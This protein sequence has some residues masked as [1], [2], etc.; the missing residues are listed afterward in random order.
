MLCVCVC[1]G[2]G[3]ET[4]I[5]ITDNSERMRGVGFLLMLSSLARPSRIGAFCSRNIPRHS[6]DNQRQ[7]RNMAASMSTSSQVQLDRVSGDTVGGSG[8]TL[9]PKVHFFC[10]SPSLSLYMFRYFSLSLSDGIFISRLIATA[11]KGYPIS[12]VTAKNL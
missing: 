12:D 5:N 10:L 3:E 2:I 11:L 6:H 8:T 4:T 1:R 7:S 9:V